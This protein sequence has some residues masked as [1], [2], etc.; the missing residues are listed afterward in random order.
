[1]LRKKGIY[2]VVIVLFALFSTACVHRAE[3]DTASDAMKSIRDERDTDYMML[4]GDVMGAGNRSID[5]MCD[6]VRGKIQAEVD[7]D[8]TKIENTAKN[9]EYIMGHYE[10]MSKSLSE[11]M[12]MV[13]LYYRGTFTEDYH[14]PKS[15]MEEVLVFLDHTGRESIATKMERR[16]S[17]LWAI[18]QHKREL[19]DMS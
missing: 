17:V 18:E 10:E 1:M 3:R 13:Y 16:E 7:Y 9:V 12:L 11:D 6:E 5:Q 8:T 19:V 14:I 15:L 4:K 2:C